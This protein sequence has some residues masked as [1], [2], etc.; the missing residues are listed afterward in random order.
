[1]CTIL[2]MSVYCFSL[3]FFIIF[4][5]SFLFSVASLSNCYPK[6]YLS[7]DVKSL[8]IHYVCARR[9]CKCGKI[10]SIIFLVLHYF[11]FGCHLRITFHT[12]W[13]DCSANSIW[14]KFD[15]MVIEIIIAFET[16]A[17]I[18]Y[19]WH[20]N[21]QR[22]DTRIHSSQRWCNYEFSMRRWIRFIVAIDGN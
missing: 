15:E 13:Y 3:D 18:S 4:F 22:V 8:A 1:M 7:N 20:S 5:S 9:L 11:F 10:N 2:S 19:L 6:C 16:M 21:P 17:K 14:W 12:I